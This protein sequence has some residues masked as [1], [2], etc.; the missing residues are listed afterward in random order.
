MRG[1]MLGVH[2]GHFEYKSSYFSAAL[3]IC[4]RARC[5]E[6]CGPLSRNRKGGAITAPPFGYG[7]IDIFWKFFP[8]GEAG[9]ADALWFLPM[10]HHWGKIPADIRW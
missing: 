9:S 2:A 5:R 1:G 7:S 3:Q 10:P 8:D 4:G 6:N